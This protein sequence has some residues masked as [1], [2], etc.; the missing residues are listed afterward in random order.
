MK[1]LEKI[2]TDFKFIALEVSKQLK[3]A[4]KYIAHP[5]EQLLEAI[6]SRDDF[7]DNL[8]G[9]IEDNCFSVSLT[10][11]GRPLSAEKANSMRA[12]NI[13]ASNLERIADHA[14]N[15]VDQM[16]Y[17][18]ERSV[19]D[20]FSFK[21]AFKEL[22]HALSKIDSALENKDINL[23]MA[24]CQC[25]YELDDIY[26]RAFE[27]IIE[28]IRSGSM[29]ESRITLLFMMHYLERMG[30]AM[31]N[32]GE[33]I[34][35]AI[36]GQKLKVHQYK[37]LEE[38]LATSDLHTTIG[39]VAFA[40]I[41]GTRSGCRIGQI[42]DIR[43]DN[44]SQ[45]V[46]FK[47]GGLKKLNNERQNIDAWQKIVPGLPP[48]IMSFQKNGR[49]ATMLVEY[50]GDATFQN[51]IL[52]AP[53]E[54]FKE[55]F[56]AL[57]ETLLHIWEKT[58]EKKPVDLAFSRQITA[59]I[60]DV[61]SVHPSFKI[62]QKQIGAVSV[63]SFNERIKIIRAI[64]RELS[65]PFSVF[66]HGDFNIDN[67]IYDP[68]LKRIHFIDLNRSGRTDYV[69]DISVFL[70]SNFRQPIFESP[71]R[72]RLNT[73]IRSFYAFAGDFARK[74]GDT[75][76]EARLALGI[77]RSLI[78]ST[79]FELNTKFAQNMFL[80]SMY[81]LER[82]SEHRPAPWEKFVLPPDTLIY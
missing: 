42:K 46:I 40:S 55:V 41:W 77:A 48:R 47:K 72:Q 12:K 37:A 59:R 39:D 29:V 35:F 49:H 22:K 25:E 15:L 31:L 51:L 74:Q 13:I 76:F 81:L 64:D 23:A 20:G 6:I 63:F 14:V 61:F 33:A 4:E 1:A 10:G 16:Q 52:N 56:L 26:T 79:R 65:A 53:D 67:I 82:L 78:T 62:P 75:S 36:I 45:R 2:N 30:D 69:Q 17:V 11:R 50:L 73:V 43:Q 54:L 71:L 21:P 70:V 34:I 38:S 60:Q 18:S 8:K 24:I 9:R 66:A 44:G 7:I 28:G 5:D 80:R 57:Q 32:V 19:L 27:K 3:D 58:A 68:K